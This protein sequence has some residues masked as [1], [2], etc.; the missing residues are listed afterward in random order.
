MATACEI[1]IPEPLT[2]AG[3]YRAGDGTRRSRLSISPLRI[4]AVLVAF[5]T[6]FIPFAYKLMGELAHQ[7]PLAQPDMVVI[8][9]LVIALVGLVLSIN[10][11]RWIDMLEARR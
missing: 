8:R 5:L 10:V 11:V 2:V 6:P 9:A 3:A 4:A 7:D 1:P